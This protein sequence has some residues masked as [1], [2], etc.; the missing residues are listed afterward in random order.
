L[1]SADI[2]MG[3]FISSS[4]PEKLSG[5]YLSQFW[6]ALQHPFGESAGRRAAARSEGDRHETSDGR[7]RE[8]I[9]VAAS[10]GRR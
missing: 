7:C 5:F 6:G 3:R 9:A 4:P 2:T 10:I 8:R 1:A